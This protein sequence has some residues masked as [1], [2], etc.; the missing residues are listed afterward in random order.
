MCRACSSNHA[1]MP[2]AAW[3]VKQLRSDRRPTTNPLLRSKMAPELLP[4]DVGKMMRS[5]SREPEGAGNLQFEVSPANTA[6]YAKIGPPGCQGCIHGVDT[7]W[8]RCVYGAAPI[9]MAL[10]F[11]P[12]PLRE[13][14]HPGARATAMDSG[15]RTSSSADPT[16]AASSGLVVTSMESGLT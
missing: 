15:A 2:Q 11:P 4:T 6:P 3:R 9:G 10:G 7:V 16:S 12:T 8:I 5:D 1:T 13:Q 14:L